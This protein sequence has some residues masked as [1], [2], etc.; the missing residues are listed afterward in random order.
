MNEEEICKH[1]LEKYSLKIVILTK[2]TSGSLVVTPHYTGFRETP[3]VK[4]ADTVGAGDSF[5][6]G[7]AASL[8][9]GKSISEAHETAVN[10]SAYVC[11]QHGAMWSI[12]NEI[13][14]QWGEDTITTNLQQ[15]NVLLNNRKVNDKSGK[16][17]KNAKLTK[18]LADI[19][20]NLDKTR[21]VTAA[22]NGTDE[23]NPLFRAEALDLIG[24]NYHG[25]YKRFFILSGNHYARFAS[26]LVKK[27]FSE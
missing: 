15:A 25:R 4:V 3:V 5:T 7:F 11:T 19:V 22:C 24:Y 10:V 12:G 13:V 18:H 26:R 17:G 14:E 16:L 6:A 2:G 20:K 23:N 21:L 9:R 27:I 1:L 8:L